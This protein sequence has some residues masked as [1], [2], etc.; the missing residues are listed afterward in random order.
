MR[1]LITFLC[2]LVTFTEASTKLRGNEH[3]SSHVNL[4]PGEEYPDRF[5]HYAE[6]DTALPVIFTPEGGKHLGGVTVS[7]ATLD[8]SDSIYYTTDG[9]MPDKSDHL[10]T[11]P[12]NVT[13]SEVIRAR[14]FHY[15]AV[16]GPVGSNTYVTELDHDLPVVC[17]STEP[18]NLWDENTGIFVFGPNPPGDF[19]YFNAN[20]WKDWERPVHIELYDL[21]GIK[22]IDQDAGMKVYGAWSRAFDQKSVALYA[23]KAYGKGSFKYRFFKDKPIEKFESIVLRNSGNDNMGL[24]FHDCFMTGL[25]R[26]MDIDR[27]AYQPSAVYIN[28]VYWGLLNIREKISNDYV[29]E[30]H[31]V[32]AESINL[33]E[34]S[35]TVLD[36][37]RRD[38]QALVNYMYT[39]STLQN[40]ADYQWVGN[41]IDKDN[42][43]KYQLTEIYLNNRDWPSN[44]IKFWNTNGPGSKW[45][46]ILYDTDFGFGIWDETDYQLNTLEFATETNGP[47]WPNPPWSTLILRRLLSNLAFRNDFIIQFCDRLNLDFHP[48]RI[49]ADLDS[50]RDLYDHEIVYNFDRWW[51]SY[52][53]WLWRIDSRRVFGNYRPGYC[54]QHLKQQFMLDGELNV[55]VDVS[56]QQEGY[57]KLNTIYPKSFPFKGIYFE[58]IPITLKAFPKPGYKF[59]RW[60]GSVNSNQTAISFNMNTGANFKAFFTEATAADLSVVINEINYN[61]PPERDTHDWIELFNNGSSTVDL[62]GWVIIDGSADSGYIF[63]D[64]TWLTPG[65]YLVICRDL[66]DFKK[67]NPEVGN[68]LGD[69]PFGLSSGGDIVRL[70][71]KEGNLVDAVNY[72]INS[73]WPSDANGKGASLEL[74]NPELDNALGENWWASGIGGT[75]GKQNGLSGTT[76]S[77]DLAVGMTPA[78]DCFPNP[79]HDYTTIRF[80]ITVAGYC[81]IDIVDMQGRVIKVLADENLNPGTYWLDWEGNDLNDGNLDGGIYTVR[82]IGNGSLETKKL[83]KLR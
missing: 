62:S 81:R 63:Q 54:R 2:L 43:I 6:G 3:L 33:L 69:L 16:P 4:I 75:P 37:N 30:N 8:V 74:S 49:N 41:R 64:G 46:W 73:P 24:Q 21:T 28:G 51:G 26:E 59:V 82:L 32:D 48:G 13:G 53:Q 7:L 39:K 60:E 79:F 25:T 72:G 50:L 42:F 68:S 20:F 76:G 78:L 40:D 15:G 19:P 67:F 34:G 23:R 83:V 52:N 31:N 35:G 47:N 55:Q 11:G 17:L 58:N 14:A 65:D 9:S 57:V 5:D 18:A 22:R 70:Y 10:Y 1:F 61:S 71:D 77:V 45:R 38:Y 29:S 44:N 80:N 12:V 27:L 56:D 36:G 66:E